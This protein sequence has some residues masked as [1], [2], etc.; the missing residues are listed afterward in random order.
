MS[1]VRAET[2]VPIFSCAAR[3]VG[4]QRV[5]LPVNLRPAALM[6]KARR[7]DRFL[8]GHVEVDDVR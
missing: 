7:V 2:W 5:R 3:S 6:M 8:H 1:P 4:L